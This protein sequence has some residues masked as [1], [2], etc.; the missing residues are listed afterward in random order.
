[1]PMSS[2][3][4][5]NDTSQWHIEQKQATMDEELS[6]SYV[7]RGMNGNAELIIGDGAYPDALGRAVSQLHNSTRTRGPIV[8]VGDGL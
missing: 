7:L 6:A 4:F 3:I 1:M 2:E 5:V 8:N